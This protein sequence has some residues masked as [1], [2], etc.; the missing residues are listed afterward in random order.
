[1]KKW[2]MI[3]AI[4]LLVALFSSCSENNSSKTNEIKQ[5][6]SGVENQL[7]KEKSEMTEQQE[8]VFR[9][10]GLSD[11]EIDKMK[12]NGLSYKE[13]SFAD[14]ALMMLN[15]LEEKYGEQFQVVGGD[16]P[17][18]LSDEYWI[19]AEALEGDYAGEKFNVQYIGKDSYKDG[20]TVLVKQEE[21]CEALKRLIQSKFGNILIFPSVTGEYG[22]ELA[23]DMTGEEMLKIVYYDYNII[24]TDPDISSEEEFY[25]SSEGIMKFLDDNEV[26]SGGPV[27]YLNGPAQLNM[28]IED[29]YALLDKEDAFR[30]DDYIRSGN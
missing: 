15:Y 9:S 7:N 29:F 14:T 17:G 30:W 19:T 12:K 5:S 22:S 3:I 28:T 11:E 23:L 20:Y 25:K 8:K 2:L 16:I 18:I 26:N 10:Y 6:N 1:M 24:I 21:A 4:T 13:Q 27:R